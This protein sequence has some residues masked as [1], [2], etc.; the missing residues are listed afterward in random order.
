MAQV[1]V[2][3]ETVISRP[4][5]AVAGYASNPDN[6]PEWYENISSVEWKTPRPLEVGSRIAFVANFLGKR[7]E[8]TYEIVEWTP[9]ERLVMRTSEGP[10]PME[11]TYTWESASESSTRMK[12]RNRGRP[13]GFSAL[14]APF[15]T[16]MMRRANRKDL[17]L[18][19]QLLE[20]D[21]RR[22]ST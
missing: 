10:F 12:L 7:L 13:A 19:K 17:S 4:R 5:D 6:A 8:Y 15:M 2:R 9:G 3:T 16:F 18:L 1:D 14:A 20:E 11:T 22:A 21:E